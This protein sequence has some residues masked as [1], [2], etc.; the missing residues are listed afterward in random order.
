MSAGL[1][2]TWA[3]RLGVLAFAVASVAV[4]AAL[5]ALGYSRITGAFE[6]PSADLTD[7]QQARHALQS[8]VEL[9][10]GVLLLTGVLGVVLLATLGLVASSPHDGAHSVRKI[11]LKLCVLAVVAGLLVGPITQIHGG[12]AMP[13]NISS[14]GVSNTGDRQ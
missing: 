12:P 4:V 10:S 13:A 2:R 8:A 3:E 6:P 1:R 5:A 7:T 9:I 11:A 14:E